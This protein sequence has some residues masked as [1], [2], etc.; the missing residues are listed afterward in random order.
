M[1]FLSAVFEGWKREP[2]HLEPCVGRC[3]WRYQGMAA[4]AGDQRLEYGF[5]AY[6]QVGLE[7]TVRLITKPVTGAS[8]TFAAMGLA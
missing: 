2:P 1:P 6:F 5:R 8:R 4:S 3:S 7:R